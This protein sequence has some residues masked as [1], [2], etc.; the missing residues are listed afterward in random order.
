MSSNPYEASTT[1]RHQPLPYRSIEVTPIEYMQRSYRMIKEQYLLFLGIVFCALLIGA[2]G[3]FGIL[4]GPM[5]TG[6]YLCF[7]QC[8]SGNPVKFDTLF[9]GF[10]RFIP[11]MLVTLIVL[12]CNV[13]ISLIFITVVGAATLLI[14]AYHFD[15]S[16]E[17]PPVALLAALFSLAYVFLLLST[18]IIFIPFTFC[19]QLIAEHDMP[20]GP[21]MQTSFRAAWHNLLPLTLVY[22]CLSFFGIVAALFCYLPLFFLAPIQIGVTFI[23]YRDTFPKAGERVTDFSGMPNAL[24]LPN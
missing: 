20:A 12:L 15:T 7:L 19:F 5:I 21:A 8:E 16:Q 6:V 22:I 18:V 17:P 10:E 2:V 23:L 14:L 13:L 4:L 9:R 1:L 11:S 3:P 24:T